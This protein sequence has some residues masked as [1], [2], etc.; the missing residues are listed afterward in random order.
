MRGYFT[1]SKMGTLE[2]LESLAKDLRSCD[3]K[4]A[5]G[6]ISDESSIFNGSIVVLVLGGSNNGQNKDI[7]RTRLLLRKNSSD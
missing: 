5:G 1:S 4:I 3:G 7:R 2:M 6:S